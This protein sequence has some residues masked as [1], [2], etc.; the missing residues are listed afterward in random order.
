MPGVTVYWLRLAASLF[1]H[2]QQTCTEFLLSC[3]CSDRCWEY[4]ECSNEY[5]ERRGN[6]YINN[7]LKYI[8]IRVTT[9]MCTA[10]QL[11][12]CAQ[13][14]R[15]S[16]PE[17]VP[18]ELWVFRGGREKGWSRSGTCTGKAMET[19]EST[20]WGQS[21]RSAGRLVL[22]GR[23]EIQEL[24][25]KKKSLC[26]LHLRVWVFVVLVPMIHW[27]IL[28]VRATKSDLLFRKHTLAA[29]QWVERKVVTLETGRP[30]RKLW[31]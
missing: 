10:L 23:W 1:I 27:K 6:Y 18:P 4:K 20:M 11:R 5:T 8:E 7:E 9:R 14:R 17:S 21:V 26:R 25:E 2:I 16:C 31:Q 13:R 24:D 3:Q 29:V 15:K 12:I 22:A 30:S 28:I 19:W